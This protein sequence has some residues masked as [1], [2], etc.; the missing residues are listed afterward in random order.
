MQLLDADEFLDFLQL[1][2]FSHV[3]QRFRDNNID[4]HA[5][6]YS[7]KPYDFADRLRVL[8]QLDVQRLIELQ[9]RAI[10]GLYHR[11]GMAKAVACLD[12]SLQTLIKDLREV[13][14][15]WQNQCAPFYADVDVR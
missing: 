2:S 13:K 14:C 10:K 15:E 5:F 9:Q 12:T 6:V 4:G 3:G 8:D 1:Y 11:P 7:L